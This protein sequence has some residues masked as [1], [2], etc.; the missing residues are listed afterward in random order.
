MAEGPAGVFCQAARSL[1]LSFGEGTE[2]LLYI[3]SAGV[4][5]W[6]C[7]PPP[8]SCAGY[9]ASQRRIFCRFFPIL[10]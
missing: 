7:K 3:V 9:F 2:A 1:R 8:L 4:G 6:C 10:F 5:R